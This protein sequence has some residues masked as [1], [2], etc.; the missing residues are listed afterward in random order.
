MSKADYKGHKSLACMVITHIDN[1]RTAL[2][3]LQ[4]VQLSDA[5]GS[6]ILHELKALRE[7]EEACKAELAANEQK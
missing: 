7:I 2:E 4:K 6:Y 3:S 1:W 5:D